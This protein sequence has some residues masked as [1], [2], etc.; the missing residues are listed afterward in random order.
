MTYRT[1]FVVEVDGEVH[2][3]TV[4]EGPVEDHDELLTRLRRL[5]NEDYFSVK[6]L[7]QALRII[8]RSRAEIPELGTKCGMKNCGQEAVKVLTISEHEDL[9]AA[10]GLPPKITKL[11]CCLEHTLEW[12]IGWLFGDYDIGVT[13]RL[14]RE[15]VFRALAEAGERISDARI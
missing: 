8:E 2:Y 9:R 5:G 3:R 10:I 14:I 1:R 11:P 13:P 7:L 15:L 12:E 6:T 4:F